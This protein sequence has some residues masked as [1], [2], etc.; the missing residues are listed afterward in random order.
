[1]KE[2]FF[3]SPSFLPWQI[4]VVFFITGLFCTKLFLGGILFSSVLLL[5]LWLNRVKFNLLVF[6]FVFLAGFMYGKVFLPLP[7]IKEN[8]VLPKEKIFLR[9]K[10][11]KVLLKPNKTLVMVV[12]DLKYFRGRRIKKLYGKG[13]WI[14]KNFSFIPSSGQIV[15]GK[16]FIRPIRGFLNPGGRDIKKY[17]AS[18]G[19][20]YKIF[21]YGKSSRLY[22]Y[23]KRNF[24]DLIRE[25]IRLKILKSY[26][27]TQG[28]GLLLTLLLGD[29]SEVSDATLSLIR[30][31]SLSHCFALSGMH[32]GFILFFGWIGAWLLGVFLPEI[33]YHIP[34]YKLTILISVPFVL[35]YL[36]LNHHVPSLLRSGLMFFFMSGLFLAG[37][38]SFLIDGIFL[39]LLVFVFLLPNQLFE[40]SLQLSYSAI[41]SIAILLPYLY[42][43]SVYLKNKILKFFLF[44][45]GISL[46]AMIG[47]FPLICYYFGKT[48]FSL[49][50]N[51]IF[52]PV[53]GWISLPSGIIGLIFSFIPFLEVLSKFFISLS[54]K[55]LDFLIAVL[56]FLKNHHLLNYVILPKPG[57]I[58]VLGFWIF[59]IGIFLVF[60][61]KKNLIVIAIGLCMIFLPYSVNKLIQR[62]YLFNL[63]VLDV[64]DG[65]SYLIKTKKGEKILINGGG[66]R[67]LKYGFGESIIAN[68]IT[69][70]DLPKIKYV[71]LTYPRF[72]RI[73]GL[74]FLLDH[75]YVD[76]FIYSGELPKNKW[77]MKV[78]LKTLKRLK[79]V[80]VVKKEAVLNEG[81]LVFEI[82]RPLDLY[83]TKSKAP[84]WIL[85]RKK[86]NKKYFSVFLSKIPDFP[87]RIQRDLKVYIL[88]T[89]FSRFDNLKRL[90]TLCKIINP[91][92]VIISCGNKEICDAIYNTLKKLNIK[93]FSTADRGF[94]E[95]WVR[96]DSVKIKTF[97]KTFYFIPD[98]SYKLNRSF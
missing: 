27:E 74:Y 49:Y 56:E 87:E 84:L 12:D 16:V 76:E 42:K 68:A 31:G 64:G 32:L 50:L 15:K 54:I 79:N 98:L 35:F 57:W 20:F 14:W 71:I 65:E 70:R 11:E 3:Y 78:F 62:R 85:L 34:R 8:V 83:K 21:T 53:I 95:V 97:N 22:F 29:K 6:F 24:L 28:R 48:S 89:Y 80:K 7:K 17:W 33:F 55:S 51:L 2:R 77:D 36:L 92:A 30:E 41:I 39:S 60:K 90:K 81:E 61:E 58:E 5:I 75:F 94:I 19:V 25:K 46:I 73:R 1:M 96:S 43:L 91:K 38:P 86:G 23:G 44:T 4:S 13:I 40:I 69:Y 26:R 63:T 18:K 82:F 10:I 67:F 45:L 66:T 93:V 9:A 72:N 59:C 37:R 52:I 47:V 88:V